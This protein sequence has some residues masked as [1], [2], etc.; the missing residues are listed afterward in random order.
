MTWIYINYNLW[1]KLLRFCGISRGR[2]L[3]TLAGIVSDGAVINHHA[4]IPTGFAAVTAKPTRSC[5]DKVKVTVLADEGILQHWI[6]YKVNNLY[7]LVGLKI[8]NCDK[9]S[10]RGIWKSFA[11]HLFVCLVLQSTSVFSDRMSLIVGV[12]FHW[13]FCLVALFWN[14]KL[15]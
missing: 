6:V 4:G 2:F 15:S 8:E 12:F 5:D 7:W 3:L 10:F 1:W 14:E 13:M 9:V 11:S